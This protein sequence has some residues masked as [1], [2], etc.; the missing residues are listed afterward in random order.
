[1][2]LRFLALAA[3]LA[4]ATLAGTA[5]AQDR[6][7]TFEISPFGGGYFGGTIFDSGHA[8][9]DVDTDVAYGVR[10]AYNINRVFG[11]EFDWTQAKANLDAHNLASIPGYPPAPMDG[12]IGR[13]THDVYEV[14]GIFNFGKGRASGYVGM[15][16]GAAVMKVDL[17]N[18]SSTSDTRFTSNFSAGFKGWVT[19]HFGFRFDGRFRWTDTNHTTSRD[20]WCDYYGYCYSYHTTWY[21]SGELTGGLMFAF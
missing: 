19:P 12:K 15:G 21:S 1:M 13:L 5:A 3:C 6:S 20:T 7:G 9:V 14:N 16:L 17:T 8:H 2:R 11:V 18:A 4:A 10:F